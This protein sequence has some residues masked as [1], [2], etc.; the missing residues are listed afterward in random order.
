MD[1]E[2]AHDWAIWIASK[3]NRSDIFQNIVSRLYGV[4]DVK[5][6]EKIWGLH[7]KNPLGL[8]AGFDKNGTTPRAMQ[9]L[10]FGFIE[11]GSIT[12]KSST[13]NSKPRA[14]R[15]PKDHSL[16][17]RMGLNN[18]GATKVVERLKK[19]Q[20]DIPL[21]LNIAK[22]NDPTISGDAAVEDYIESYLLAQKVADYIT[23]NISCPNTGEG[24]TF[25]DPG[26]LSELLAGIKQ[27]ALQ[28]GFPSNKL[29][30]SYSSTYAHIPTTVKFSVD[31]THKDLMNLLEICE[32]YGI[33]GYVATN[34]SNKREGLGYSKKELSEIGRGGLSGRAIA[35]RSLEMTRWL[36]EELSGGK[37]VISVGG[38]DSVNSALE[39]LEAGAHLLQLYTAL[40]YEGPGLISDI[41]KACGRS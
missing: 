15:L 35:K 20:L 19:L 11:V 22:T 36:S 30:T 23:I 1:A 34:T 4:V 14:F 3:T 27:R 26:A 5:S 37:P 32:D 17:N 29:K 38:I 8:A 7:F 39:R 12:A 31:T 40:V 9:A 21:G 33:D 25:E 6:N 10:G 24:K 13:G 16:I 28:G 18:Q 41:V 2:H